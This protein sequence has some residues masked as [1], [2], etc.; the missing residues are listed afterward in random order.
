[1]SSISVHCSQSTFAG[2]GVNNVRV[3]FINQNGNRTYNFDW[4]CRDTILEVRINP[5]GS[6]CEESNIT[7]ENGNGG[8]DSE[9][10][11]RQDT[12][13]VD[14]ENIV[15]ASNNLVFTDDNS[16][17]RIISKGNPRSGGFY[18]RIATII[19]TDPTNTMEIYGLCELWNYN[20]D[21]SESKFRL[22]RI[23]PINPPS[24][25]LGGDGNCP[26]PF[27][28]EPGGV[29]NLTFEI[30][31][32]EIG[33][34]EDN[35]DFRVVCENNEGNWEINLTGEV[36]EVDCSCFVDPN[37]LNEITVSNA[38]VPVLT[39]EEFD[40]M[41]V[42]TIDDINDEC[43]VRVDEIF[44][45]DEN[46]VN[47]DELIV[48]LNND[49]Y[50]L[51]AGQ[52]NEW[53]L[54]DQGN[55]AEEFRKNEELSFALELTPSEPIE[56][57][58]TFRIVYSVYNS[59]DELQETCDY[60]FYLTGEGCTE[61]CPELL[62][63]G[64]P[65]GVESNDLS[66]AGQIIRVDAVDQNDLWNTD[67][68]VNPETVNVGESLALGDCANPTELFISSDYF[69]DPEGICEQFTSGQLE[70]TINLRF[71]ERDA[72]GNIINYCTENEGRNFGINYISTREDDS[73]IDRVRF[74]V[75]PR[76]AS[77]FELESDESIQYTIRF[78]KPSFTEVQDLW[79]S[80]QKDITDSTFKYRLRISDENSGCCLILNFQ[81]K[82]STY[83][84]FGPIKQLY[85]FNQYTDKQPDSDYL[86]IKIDQQDNNLDDAPFGIDRVLRTA[87]PPADYD[88]RLN[89]VE[90]AHTPDSD[91]TFFI[92]VPVSG[93]P[94]DLG[95]TPGIFLNSLQSNIFDFISEQPIANYGNVAVINFEDLISG[96]NE[97]PNRIAQSF[98]VFDTDGCFTNPPSRTK[99]SF[100]DPGSDAPIDGI[101][102][103]EAGDV[104][105]LWSNPANGFSNPIC[106][107]N[108]PCYIALIY[109]VEVHN[110]LDTDNT[111]DLAN[112]RCRILYPIRR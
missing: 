63:S 57:K 2:S 29:I 18:N 55:L 93:P 107:N 14:C 17:D 56:T 34:F 92:D 21:F 62:V 95:Q 69:L 35:F 89:G 25:V 20:R 99:E 41:T 27:L 13:T 7:G 64:L 67:L 101:Y 79:N 22:D 76:D 1:L 109:I 49:P 38:T 87:D 59:F 83:A 48:P 81:A 72:N 77:N 10:E 75:T 105:M 5:A 61:S 58:D 24:N 78:D 42:L 108:T 47:Y 12:L 91:G 60:T 19:N 82:I 71:P 9:R 45:V 8:P 16:G 74:E 6:D 100:I 43:Y 106:S 70:Y 112:I 40:P 51:T 3:D 110:G 23:A 111:S 85:A 32:D 30:N 50:I 86:E 73:E 46:G 96:T 52:P 11:P 94:Q 90:G 97:P 44:R 15:N 31:T 28:L 103:I 104:F 68:W 39:T 33:V 4:I 26:D 102:D 53:I 37:G 98:S 66:N 65:S 88:E 80:G 54:I 36:E 84:S